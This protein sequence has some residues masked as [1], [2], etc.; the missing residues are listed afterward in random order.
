MISNELDKFQYVEQ[1]PSRNDSRILESIQPQSA[2][3]TAPSSEGALCAPAPEQK[4]QI[5]RRYHNE[6]YL[7]T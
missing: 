5:I 7:G 2:T 3:L 6:M 1:F 4:T